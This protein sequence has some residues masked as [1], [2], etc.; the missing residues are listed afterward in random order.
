VTLLL[1]VVG[2]VL[3][4]VQV[5]TLE[6]T[7][8]NGVF[9]QIDSLDCNRPSLTPTSK[10]IESVND[11]HVPSVRNIVDTNAPSYTEPTDPQWGIIGA[12]PGDTTIMVEQGQYLVAARLTNQPG[13]TLHVQWGNQKYPVVAVYGGGL[14]WKQRYI[15]VFG[16]RHYMLPIQWD[17]H[18]SS[19]EPYRVERWI[20]ATGPAVPRDED[21]L[22]GQCSD[23]HN[24][25][26]VGQSGMAVVGLE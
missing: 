14:G 18:S 8:T 9:A 10:G 26:D 22:E 16:E 12:F 25:T 2:L 7:A 5:G 11:A 4:S 15:T 13:D 20:T 23:C 3:L 6:G 17:E 21:S 19:W 1:A 24:A